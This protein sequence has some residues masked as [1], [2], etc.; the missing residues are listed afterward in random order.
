M[1]DTGHRRRTPDIGH[2]TAKKAKIIYPP[3]RGVDIM[4]LEV[5]LVKDQILQKSVEFPRFKKNSWVQVV[6]HELPWSRDAH[7][8]SFSEFYREI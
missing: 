2:R 5:Y 7:I 4:L 8:P 6:G 3:P 1:R